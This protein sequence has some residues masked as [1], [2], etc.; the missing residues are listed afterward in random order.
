M[1]CK[2]RKVVYASRREAVH[3][4]KQQ[5]FGKGGNAPYVCRHCGHWHL[6]HKLP[7]HVRAKVRKRKR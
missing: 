1:G 7:S 6:G 3:V 5:S 2:T 4:L